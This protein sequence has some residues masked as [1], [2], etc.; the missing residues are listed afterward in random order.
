MACGS[1]SLNVHSVVMLS[2]LKKWV[3]DLCLLSNAKSN[4]KIDN[5]CFL[6]STI[7]WLPLTFMSSVSGLTECKVWISVSDFVTLGERHVRRS[8]LFSASARLS[9]L[10]AGC[11]FICNG[12]IWAWYLFYFSNL[13]KGSKCRLFLVYTVAPHKNRKAT[14][15]PVYILNS[16][17]SFT[18]EAPQ[19]FC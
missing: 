17:L 4:V 2:R 19:H 6:H 5:M 14:T 8:P 13:A 11:G 15:C 9:W 12:Q 7:S 16:T 1:S 10:A 3:I 18:A